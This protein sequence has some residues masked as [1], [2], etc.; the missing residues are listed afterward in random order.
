[1]LNMEIRA[2]TCALLILSMLRQF[3]TSTQTTLTVQLGR[4]KESRTS[5]LS[6]T[7]TAPECLRFKE[8]PAFDAGRATNSS[9]MKPYRWQAFRKHINMEAE[10]S[11]SDDSTISET[12]KTELTPSVPPYEVNSMILCSHTDNLFYEAKIIAVKMQENGDYMYTVHYQGWSKRYDE[13]IPHSRS[14]SRFRPFTPDNIEL[15]KIEMKE[16]KARAAELI[17]KKRPQKTEIRRGRSTVQ[18]LE[19]SSNSCRNVKSL[20][21]YNVLGSNSV[22]SLSRSSSTNEAISV[23]EKLKGLLENDRNLVENELM[24]PRLPC[25]LTVSKIMKE[26]VMH[27]RKLDAVCSEVK[28]HKGRARYWK[29][30]VAALDECAENMKSFFDLIIAS[31]ILY[32]SEKL[33][34]KDL[35]EETS[36]VVHLHNISDILKEPER[37]VCASEYYGFIYLLR[38]LVKF[39]EMIEFMLCDND[40]KEILTVFVQSFLR[41]LGNNSE[42]FFDPE[43]DYET[44][45][46][47]YKIRLL[48]NSKI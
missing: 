35:T 5:S 44:I 19:S 12:I 37:G 3:S 43:V 24:L 11:S 4:I 22:E 31:D 9:L 28:V 8:E 15:A 30:V 27:V 36:G 48:Q 13:N 23:P 1:M 29:G 10:A 26:Y 42:K 38:L 17:K 41:Y 34:H 21:S 14:A 32:P 39:P 20:G 47:E 16:A 6:S 40:S 45:T 18:L 2:N 7:E 33:R 46:E 25:R